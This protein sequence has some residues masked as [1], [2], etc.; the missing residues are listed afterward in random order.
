VMAA[1]HIAGFAPG[2]SVPAP[3]GASA[4]GNGAAPQGAIG[5]GAPSEPAADG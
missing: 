2:A 1:E 5:A 3:T 4:L